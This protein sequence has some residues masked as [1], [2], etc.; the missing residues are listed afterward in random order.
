MESLTIALLQISCWVCQKNNCAS[1]SNICWIYPI[2]KS[3]V[4]FLIHSAYHCE[5]FLFLSWSVANE[6]TSHGISAF[7]DRPSIRTTEHD[8]HNNKYI[9]LVNM[10]MWLGI[11]CLVYPQ[12]CQRQLTQSGCIKATLITHIALN[13]H[14]ISFVFGALYSRHSKSEFN[15]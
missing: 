7:T 9:W 12:N 3:M 2:H 5:F 10:A 15:A 13:K 11:C 14:C 4:S 6:F 8:S 1:K